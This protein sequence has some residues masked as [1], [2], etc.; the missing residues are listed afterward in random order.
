MG[1]AGCFFGRVVLGNNGNPTVINPINPAAALDDPSVNNFDFRFMKVSFN[2]QV[3]FRYTFRLDSGNSLGL[4]LR[5]NNPI[6]DDWL[7]VG[8]AAGPGN[9]GTGFGGTYR[10]P[11]GDLTK[12]NR[13][14]TPD[15]VARFTE[16]INFRLTATYT[17]GGSGNTR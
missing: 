15:L 9:A 17:F 10:Q 4:A 11:D 12:P 16:P 1:E 2:S 5:V 8:D 7:P 3:N 13:V 6:N 14:L